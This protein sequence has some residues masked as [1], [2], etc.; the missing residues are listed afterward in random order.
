MDVA[1]AKEITM[2]HHEKNKS[3]VEDALFLHNKRSMQSDG[4]AMF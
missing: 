4:F 2:Q 3:L 1:I